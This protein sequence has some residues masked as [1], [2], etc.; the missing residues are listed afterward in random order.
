[1]QLNCVD[2]A[3]IARTHVDSTALSLI[4][5]FA[6]FYPDIE[7][8]FA[9]KVIPGLADGTRRILID[10]DVNSVRGLAILK[11]EADERKICTLWVH[12]NQRK[13][14]LGQRLI[15]ES[16]TWLECKKPTLTVPEEAIA[17]FHGLLA[18]NGFELRQHAIDYYRPGVCEF[19]YN[20]SL[21]TPLAGPMLQ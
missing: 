18:R 1:M 8:W 6:R 2:S 15:D 16:I 4:S 17:D 12:P 14:G 21:P 9:L 11:K 13:H 10:R 20:G 3:E 7:D 19:V 5:S